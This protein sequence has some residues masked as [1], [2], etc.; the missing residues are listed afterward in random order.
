MTPFQSDPALY[1]IMSNG[2]LMGLS[3]RYVDDLLRAGSLGFRQLAKKAN[4]LIQM[5]ED[6]HIPCTISGFSIARGKDGSLEQSQHFYLQKQ[7]RLHLYASVSEF[8]SMCMRLSWLANTRQDYQ[9]EIS[10]RAQVTE[11]RYLNEQPVIVRRLK[12]RDKAC[13]RPPRLP[14]DPYPSSGVA[15]RG[16]HRRFIFRKQP[17]PIHAAWPYLLSC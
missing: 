15:S 12:N 16:W 2:H 14:Q 11:D 10:Q 4:E 9:F 7:E 6:E 5:G 13:H 3:G 8:R 17:R 1:K